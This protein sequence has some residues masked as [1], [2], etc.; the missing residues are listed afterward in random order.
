[1]DELDKV[2]NEAHDSKTDGSIR[3]ASAIFWNSLRSH[4]VHLFTNCI[5][6]LLAKSRIGLGFLYTWMSL[7]GFLL[8]RCQK[9]PSTEKATMYM[10]TNVRDNTIPHKHITATNST[11]LCLF[12]LHRKSTQEYSDDAYCAK[13]ALSIL[14]VHNEKHNTHIAILYYLPQY[15]LLSYD[16]GSASGVMH[17]YIERERENTIKLQLPP[18]YFSAPPPPTT[19]TTFCLDLH[20]MIFDTDGTPI[21]YDT[22]HT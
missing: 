18:L 12:T 2:S 5:E 21:S 3:V 8:Q 16:C 14:C 15:L 9:V 22:L 10:Y 17:Y 4:L 11:K 20:C 1:M 19:T 7:H 13:N 6:S